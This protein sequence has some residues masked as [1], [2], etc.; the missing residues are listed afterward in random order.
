MKE[1]LNIALPKGR[2][3]EKAYQLLKTAATNVLPLKIPAES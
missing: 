1:M 3:G 2:L